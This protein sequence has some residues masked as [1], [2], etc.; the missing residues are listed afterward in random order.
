MD[1]YEICLES[2][3]TAECRVNECPV[4]HQTAYSTRASKEEMYDLCYNESVVRFDKHV[5]AI[6]VLHKL[7]CE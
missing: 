7:K 4:F 2:D 3:A 1:R 6:D 5:L